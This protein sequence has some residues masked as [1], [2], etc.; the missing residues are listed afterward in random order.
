[1]GPQLLGWQLPPALP[2]RPASWVSVPRGTPWTFPAGRES[3]WGQASGPGGG[4][5]PAAAAGSWL[6]CPHLPGCPR[7]PASAESPA[8]WAA[9][10]SL[11]GQRQ[12]DMA[13]PPTP[14]LSPGGGREGAVPFPGEASSGGGPARSRGGRQRNPGPQTGWLLIQFMIPHEGQP[15]PRWGL[16]PSPPQGGPCTHGS[17]SGP[18]RQAPRS[19]AWGQG[20]LSPSR[21]ASQHSWRGPRVRRGWCLPSL[22]RPG[23]RRPRAQSRQEGGRGG[24]GECAESA[25]RPAREGQSL[26]RWPRATGEGG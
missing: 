2:A 15:G 20:T 4:P 1:M 11:L 5:A 7:P 22:Q 18:P 8:G 23:R 21:S 13:L 10:P 3:A 19:A 16:R 24:C 14:T 25:G 6:H 12:W 9:P 26:D 17:H